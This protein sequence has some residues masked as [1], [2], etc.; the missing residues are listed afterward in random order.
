MPPKKRKF[1]EALTLAEKQRKK[2]RGGGNYLEPEFELYHG[3]PS[4]TWEHWRTIE[5]I[6]KS[7]IFDV[8]LEDDE[9]L[10]I[11]TRNLL[12]SRPKDHFIDPMLAYYIL[13]MAILFIGVHDRR[14]KDKYRDLF[15]KNLG[16]LDENGNIIIVDTT[17]V[18][19]STWHA[20]S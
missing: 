2:L 18:A 17:N 12:R 7:R 5:S 14:Q 13:N 9:T 6:R 3:D 16:L 20:L 19:P 15:F 4:L 11:M 1:G 10:P 8:V